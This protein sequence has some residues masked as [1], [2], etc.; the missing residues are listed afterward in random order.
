M[1]PA[2]AT[3]TPTPT[4]LPTDSIL[5]SARIGLDRPVVVLCSPTLQEQIESS[6]LLDGVSF[7]GSVGDLIDSLT[8]RQSAL[9]LIHP[10]FA[11]E[12]ETQT[13]RLLETLPSRPL[14]CLMS[15]GEEINSALKAAIQLGM[16]TILPHDILRHPIELNQIGNWLATGGPDPGIESILGADAAI[17]DFQVST[18]DDKARVIEAMLDEARKCRSDARFIF[19]LRLLLEE[20]LNNAL[21]HAFQDEEGREKYSIE[22][23][24]RLADGETVVAQIGTNRRS[25]AVSIS[26]NQGRLRRETILGKI[27]RQASAEGLMDT[28]GRGLH[29]IYSLA[30]R[31][32]FTLAAGRLSQIVAYFPSTTRGWQGVAA[33]PP[34]LIFGS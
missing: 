11:D 34:L 21:F 5:Q 13:L 2:T 9:V 12:A 6:L 23:F 8:S 29:L 15:S 20:G 22:K 18:I 14:P 10:D 3:P 33:Q 25:I 31:T 26:D 16:G 19:R 17:Q 24:K 30:G 4:P 27:L 1:T 28:S 7:A 32:V